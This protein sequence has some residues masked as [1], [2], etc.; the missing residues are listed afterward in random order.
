MSVQPSST[1]E[2]ST[3]KDK[4]DEALKSISP[5]RIAIAVAAGLIVIVYLFIQDFS[6][7]DFQK[8]SWNPKT[9]YWI[10]GAFFFVLLRHF[11]YM[12]RL[13]TI[14]QGFFSWRKCFEM[15]FVWEFS[16]AVTPT[17]VGGSAVALVALSQEKISPGRTT[18]IIFYTIVLDTFFYLS[19]LLLLFSVFGFLIILPGT[20]SFS[21]MINQ[22]FGAGFFGAYLFMSVYGSLFFYGVFI[23]AKAVHRVLMAITSLPLL[24]RFKESADKMGQDMQLASG[25]LRRQK[26]QFH[27]KAFGAT[28]GAWASRFMVLNCL[29]M[30]FIAN[31]TDPAVQ[32][33]YSSVLIDQQDFSLFVQQVFIVGRQIAM[34]VIM[35]IVPTPG[36]AGA[37][38][39]SFENFH[40]DYLPAGGT[41]LL[42]MTIFW[43]FFTYYLYL[44]IGMIVVPN[45]IRKLI[46]RNKQ[47]AEAAQAAE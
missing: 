1:E 41:L 33:H 36:G 32:A 43:R 39:S 25:E 17:S 38:E 2:Q 18:M 13:R 23:N 30:A 16:S 10:A 26:W 19:S 35:A 20:T 45:W 37:A 5:G 15:I 40:S 21:E 9:L 22:Y 42:V 12:F 6:L 4:Q 7:E 27:L 14:T 29:I 44:F 47:E 46:N 24:R 8:I 34:Y 11:A 3:P 31:S 28:A